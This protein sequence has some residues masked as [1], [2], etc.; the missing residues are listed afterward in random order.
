[1]G[2]TRCCGWQQSLPLR[3]LC[4]RDTLLEPTALGKGPV[5]LLWLWDWGSD[6]MKKDQR[7]HRE[8]EQ[9][10]PWG[11]EVQSLGLESPWV[12]FPVALSSI[13]DCQWGGHMGSPRSDSGQQWGD[14]SRVCL[15]IHGLLL[16]VAV[17]HTGL[18]TEDL[19]RAPGVRSSDWSG[20]GRL[21]P[22]MAHFPQVINIDLSH[23]FR[24]H[25]FPKLI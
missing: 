12:S 17:G 8:K 20:K 22:P 10:R 2:L 25:L 21:F 24:L 9:D 18:S 3:G 11:L 16:H 1:M 15:L 19:E 13:A 5:W 23:H 4:S 6:R 7:N 14:S